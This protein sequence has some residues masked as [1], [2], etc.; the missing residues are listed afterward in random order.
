MFYELINKQRKYLFLNKIV[1]K[2]CYYLLSFYLLFPFSPALSF[3]SSLPL[4]SF[5]ARLYSLHSFLQ[6]LLLVDWHRRILGQ[7]LWDCHK[8]QRMHMRDT[9]LYILERNNLQNKAVIII[10]AFAWLNVPISP[11]TRF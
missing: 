2:E 7:S 10:F 6:F 4:L 1:R 3:S 11:A 9:R 5:S 8:Y